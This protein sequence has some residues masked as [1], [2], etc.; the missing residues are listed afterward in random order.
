MGE[1]FKT[2]ILAVAQGLTEFLPVS[3]SGHLVLLG[4]LLDVKEDSVLLAATLHAGTLVSVLSVYFREIRAVL[5]SHRLMLLIAVSSVPAGLVGVGLKLSGLDE[6]IFDSPLVAGLG[7][8]A[9]SAIL[10]R[11][12]GRHQAQSK[13]MEHLGF[14]DALLVGFAQLVAILPG[15]S[16]SG[17]T[18]CACLRLDMKRRDASTYS[19]LMSIPVIAGAAIVEIAPL[20]LK[21]E[22]VA[23][24]SGHLALLTGFAVSAA[25]GYAALKMVIESVRKGTLSKYGYYC[26]CAGALVVVWEL[27][28]MLK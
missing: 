3:S 13:D 4:K 11:L 12:P 2:V 21:P 5:S 24:A 28:A 8:L 14:G 25:V 15:V 18:I 26:M 10:L 9:T 20:F 22:K 23:D 27:V 16:R 7:L 6:I 17:S 19:F 1:L